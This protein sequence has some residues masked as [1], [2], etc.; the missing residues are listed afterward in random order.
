[1]RTCLIFQLKM[2]SSNIES[3]SESCAEINRIINKNKEDLSLKYIDIPTHSI[4]EIRKKQNG[5]LLKLHILFMLV[6]VAMYLF[7]FFIRY[8]FHVVDHNHYI[9]NCPKQKMIFDWWNFF[10]QCQICQ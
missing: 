7:T 6:V 5:K 2:E 10:L 4:E 1:M 8:F 3:E 9:T